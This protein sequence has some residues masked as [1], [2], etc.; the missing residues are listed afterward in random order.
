MISNYHV[1][2]WEHASKLYHLNHWQQAA[3][4]FE[5][6]AKDMANSSE[7]TKCLVNKALAEA[8]LGDYERAA[9]TIADAAEVGED[10]P[11]TAFVA[12]LVN[13]ELSQLA[14]AEAWFE[15]CLTGLENKDLDCG[16]ERLQFVLKRAEVQHNLE[17][18]GQARLALELG[19]E[20][21]A[22]DDLYYLPAETLFEAPLWSGR[23]SSTGATSS[24]LIVE[25]PAEAGLVES[26]TKAGAAN[27]VDSSGG[28]Q[29]SMLWASQESL[30]PSISG[31]ICDSPSKD[32]FEERLPLH[33]PISSRPQE[34]RRRAHRS[35]VVY[36][37]PALSSRSQPSP[38]STARELRSLERIRQREAANHA[39]DGESAA[40]PQAKIP[41]TW[42]GQQRQRFE[43][44]DA[45]GVSDSVQ[46]LAHFVQEFAPENTATVRRLGTR[47]QTALEAGIE[48]M[49]D[50]E[51]LSLRPAFDATDEQVPNTATRPVE[52][53]AALQMRSERDIIAT[54][55]TTTREIRCSLLKSLRSPKLDSRLQRQ[56]VKVRWPFQDEGDTA[57]SPAR[58]AS[59]ATTAIKPASLDFIMGPDGKTIIVET[60]AKTA[61]TVAQALQQIQ[62]ARKHAGNLELRT[63]TPSPSGADACILACPTA[64]SVELPLLQPTVYEASVWRKRKP[65][66]NDPPHSTPSLHTRT[67]SPSVPAS[68]HLSP[69]ARHRPVAMADGRRSA[70]PN[71]P[72]VVS[73]VNILGYILD[74]VKPEQPK[75]GVRRGRGQ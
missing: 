39:A 36:P 46:E 30:R 69:M 41:Y 74:K 61:P 49:N 57:S 75:K 9:L 50:D 21:A 17:S 13:C 43:P 3:D 19:F 11:I 14:L 12:G 37:A 29:Y 26:N 27:I 8:R 70:S 52:C 67:P 72:S 45:R 73:S 28:L 25:E 7:R 42:H 33:P 56:P 22:P 5:F 51:G 63:P 4:I 16:S 31:I 24:L 35:I 47:V 64:H 2:L 54:R 59:P 71:A 34:K 66:R 62:E 32:S 10:L 6:L 18:I 40:V 38:P 55:P 58:L 20:D 23:S 68:D 65:I 1:D 44:R 48:A 53:A 60:A 15:A